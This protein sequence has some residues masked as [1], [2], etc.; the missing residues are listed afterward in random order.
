M[1]HSPAHAQQKKEGHGIMTQIS[2]TGP[3]SVTSVALVSHAMDDGF[4]PTTISRHL[5]TDEL[6]VISVTKI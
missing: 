1:G 6:I 2:P 5:Y 4:P 3:T